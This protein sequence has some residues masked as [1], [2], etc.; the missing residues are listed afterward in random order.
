MVS[1]AIEKPR[2]ATLDAMVLSASAGQSGTSK[3]DYPDKLDARLLRI[4]VVCGLVSIMA[5]LDSTAVVV[6]QRT[7]MDQFKSSQAITSWTLA[8]YMLALATVFPISGWAADR[9]GTKRLFM[10]SVLLFTLGSLA[11]ALAPNMLLLVLFRVVQGIGG[12]LLWPLS[13]IIVTREAGPKRLGRLMAI[14]AIPAVFGPIGGP[15]LGGWLIDTLGWQWIFL[16]NVPIGLFS[17]ALAAVLLPKDE[18]APAEKLDVIG[19]L[20]LSPGVAIFLCG[21]SNIPGRHTIADHYVLIPAILGLALIAAFVWHAW[22]R[23]ANPLIDLRLLKNGVVTQANVTLFVFAV[24][25]CGT[26]LLL[27]SYFQIVLHQTP[28]QAGMHLVPNGIGALL[29]MPLAGVITDRRGPGKVV[30]IGIPM[31][32]AGLG[33]FTFGIAEQAHYVPILLIGQVVLGM[34]MGCT[35]TPLTAAVVQSLTPH[36]IA[37]GTTLMSVNQQVGGSIGAALMAV[38]LTNE[39]V[40]SDNIVAAN[41]A[42]ALQRDAST[43][44]VPVDPSAIPRAT[45]SPDFASNLLHSLSHAYTAV[46]VLGLVLVAA[47]IIPAV[48]LP[49][50]PAGQD[51]TVED[52]V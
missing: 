30:L 29:T 38:L 50:K 46:L 32:V 40:R 7:F 22:Y 15:I 14:G 34:G 45:L 19:L 44:G 9:Y 8:G 10:G 47:T 41:K 37:R 25:L 13:F 27:P 21:V 6:A 33:I 49:R 28:L 2:S 1:E 36:Q 31:I 51:S 5:A 42:A 17:F 3:R 48:F 18:S 26:G 24:A 4:A 43:S 52:S 23:A 35:L 12:G 39:F 11:C 20:L 16:V